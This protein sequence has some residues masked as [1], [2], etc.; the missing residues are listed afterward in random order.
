M[1]ANA[2]AIMPITHRPQTV[3]V[4]GEGS[5]LIDQDG[6]RYLDFIQG[7]AV[8]TLGHC[9]KQ[10]VA[11]IRQ[12]AGQLIHAGPGFYNQPMLDLA[13]LLSAN[14]LFDHVFF[15]NSGA[16]AN[17]G[18]IK[19]ARKWGQ[20]H[21][22]GAHKIIT[23]VDGFHGR[24][25]ATMSASGKTGWNGLFEPKTPGFVKVPYND[26]SA[27]MDA[28][29]S[30][31][32]A[33]MLELIQGEAGVIPATEQF[34]QNLQ[35]LKQRHNLLLIVDEVQTG[36]AR[37]GKLFC[38]QHYDI[39]PDIMTLGKGL[40]GGMPISALLAKQAASCFASGEQGGTFNG[41]PLATAAGQAVLSAVLAPGFIHEINRLS[42]ILTTELTRLADKHQ[43]GEVRGKGLLLALNT[44]SYHADA[45]VEEAMRNRLL[46]NA[47]R[48]H[49]LR[50]MPAL[51]IKADEI[52]QMLT[53][54]D[55]IFT[56]LRD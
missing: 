48:P 41:N 31:T 14:S 33:I 22:D 45:V 29:D 34:L 19:L 3:F 37:T 36:I 49:T 43:L 20:L 17:E 47:P 12:Q 26:L 4:S 39:E 56:H 21:K 7:W 40:G 25:L 55:Q 6:E 18:A 27:T 44:G 38:Y 1:I 8:N 11:A 30:D 51:N 5:Y 50:F 23:F 35:S 32:V 53:V 16:E 28:I 54:L 24:T 2:D 52:Q 9:N 15:A 46:L 13:A 10:L 42:Q